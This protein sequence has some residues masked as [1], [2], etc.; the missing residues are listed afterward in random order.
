MLLIN[1]KGRHA[2][3]VHVSDRKESR[4]NHNHTH[5]EDIQVVVY[6]ILHDLHL[7]LSFPVGLKQTRSE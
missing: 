5:I 2:Q 3:R 6:Q 7:V 4:H 1:L